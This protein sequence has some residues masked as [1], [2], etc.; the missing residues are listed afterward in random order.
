MLDIFLKVPIVLP[1]LENAAAFPSTLPRFLA[2]FIA[3]LTLFPAP[4]KRLPVAPAF[5]VLVPVSTGSTLPALLI[6]G[7]QRLEEPILLPSLVF[8][9][10]PNILLPIPFASKAPPKYLA[11][12]NN[13]NPIIEPI[14]PAPPL[15][16]K[17]FQIPLSFIPVSAVSPA[18]IAPLIDWAFAVLHWS[19]IDSKRSFVP[20]NVMAISFTLPRIS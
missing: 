15:V 5:T 13:P 20:T 6:N 3:F 17:F 9:I 8:P 2:V 7:F 10:F 14:V 4:L 16:I 18:S 1:A 11:P 12:E 19:R